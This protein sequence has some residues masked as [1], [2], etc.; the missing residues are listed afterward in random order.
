MILL[1]EQKVLEAVDKPGKNSQVKK[2]DEQGNL[3]K[4]GT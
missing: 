2:K 4:H 1:D 3:R